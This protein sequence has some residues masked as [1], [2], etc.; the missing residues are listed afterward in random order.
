MRWQGR[1]QSDN[2]EDRRG[3]RAPGGG[4]GLGLGGA[5][6]ILA[7]ALITGKSARTLSF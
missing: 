1:K 2:V 7:V 6:L 3:L 4:V 5:I